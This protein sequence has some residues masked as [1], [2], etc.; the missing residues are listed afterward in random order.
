MLTNVK[1]VQLLTQIVLLVKQTDHPN[2]LVIVMK[3]IMRMMM[4]IVLFVTES[5]KIVKLIHP[6]VQNVLENIE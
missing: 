6:L 4:E 2:L 1:L 3:D 5:V